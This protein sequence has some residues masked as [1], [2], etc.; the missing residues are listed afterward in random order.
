MKTAIALG[1]GLVG[2]LAVA[3][4][5]FSYRDQKGNLSLQARSGLFRQLTGKF[6]FD[7]QGA[8]S[9][10]SRSQ[11]VSM[12][13]ER[14][15]ATVIPGGGKRPDRIE[16]AV[17]TGSVRLSKAAPAGPTTIITGRQATYTE[18]A[19]QGR[20]VFT[21]GVT[22]VNANTRKRETLTASGSQ[23]EAFLDPQGNTVGGGSNIRTARLTGNVRVVIVQA[24]ERA[25]TI[26]ATGQ[27][28]DLDNRTKPATMVL[29]GGVRVQGTGNSGF[30]NLQNVQKATMRLNEQGEL[31]SLEI[32][33]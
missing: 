20:A 7:L 28:L 1:F 31:T 25:G 5:V 10:S 30:G 6:S 15:V 22:L 3:Q 9:A 12:R 26:T 23:G 19:S 24:G 14:V 13:A 11:R 2:A 18:E 4:S 17:G 29:T 32:G 27:R 21:G 8:V 16:R 33:S